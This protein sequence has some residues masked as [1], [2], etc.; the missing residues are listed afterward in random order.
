MAVKI[1]KIE[2]ITDESSMIPKYL[3]IRK[4]AVTPIEYEQN[5][6]GRSDRILGF[7]QLERTK[8][9]TMETFGMVTH[10]PKSIA[11]THQLWTDWV[12]NNHQFTPT[13]ENALLDLFSRFLDASCTHK[14]SRRHA[15]AA[16][17]LKES[18]GSS[19]NALST[20]QS[21]MDSLL[22]EYESRIKEEWDLIKGVEVAVNLQ[23][24][25]DPISTFSFDY[26]EEGLEAPVFSNGSPPIGG[27]L[28]TSTDGKSVT[29]HF[30]YGDNRS[31]QDVPGICD[32][33]TFEVVTSHGSPRPQIF[34]RSY[35]T[36]Q[37]EYVYLDRGG[38][39]VPKAKL[40]THMQNRRINVDDVDITGLVAF[41]HTACTQE[42]HHA[43]KVEF[44]LGPD[45]FY[46]NQL[47][48]YHPP[49][50]LDPKLIQ[51]LYKATAMIRTLEDLEQIDTYTPNINIPGTII[52]PDG[53][54]QLSIPEVSIVIQKLELMIQS[55]IKTAQTDEEK[56]WW[57]TLPYLARGD[58]AT[59]RLINAMANMSPNH[60]RLILPKIPPISV[61]N[62]LSL[63]LREKT[64]T[65][66]LI[67]EELMADNKLVYSLSLLPDTPPRSEIG[68]KAFNIREALTSA[69]LSTP[70]AISLST[71]AF[72]EIIK[73]NHV[74]SIW[75]DLPEEGSRTK[76]AA[77][78]AEISQ[79]LVKVPPE[80]LST[81]ITTIQRQCINWPSSTYLSTL[82][83][84]SSAIL[85]DQ[86]DGNN[87]AGAFASFPN[88]KISN[89]ENTIF[90]QQPD[91]LEDGILA[92]IK[93]SF[94]P[95]MAKSI[96]NLENGARNATLRNW[97]MP[98]LVM[99]M[100]NA[101]CSGVVLR[102]NPYT[103]NPNEI[104]I[105]VQ[106]GTGGAVETDENRGRIRIT[107]QDS[108]LREDNPKLTIVYVEGEVE[109]PLHLKDLSHYLGTEFGISQILAIASGSDTISKHER[110]P[111]DSEFAV[112]R[113]SGK[114]LWTQTRQLRW[115]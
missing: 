32:T 67:N 14:A 95:E 110:A 84:R 31:A 5:D 15:V 19:D 52:F 24:F 51:P 79:S 106:T 48:E 57:S 64:G 85:E 101:A 91:T 78:F 75:N 26:P 94:T 47:T 62:R 36:G 73:Y 22:S 92:V 25:T 28:I 1:E 23:E 12:D 111:Q 69:D 17:W 82:I 77:M 20:P 16:S 10:T 63:T 109:R 90:S 7:P 43:C 113:N 108:Q 6:I 97:I 34:R 37:K 61:G 4:F 46:L 56:Q 112:V 2:S 72:Y 93:S 8:Q 71:A 83:A 38:R 80:I 107:I 42:I 13:T 45:G 98:V 33:V 103:H 60:L 30:A 59:H 40:P 3:A 11:L 86:S 55:R 70:P 89:N 9:R 74:D 81:L 114:I 29:A 115:D 65:Y 18:Q 105:E 35:K 58:A 76:L 50:R 88:L 87:H 100:I 53:L 41:A 102:H 104:L 66:W 27:Y 99:P 21:I 49:E 54:I 39:I 68:L 44:S 96:G